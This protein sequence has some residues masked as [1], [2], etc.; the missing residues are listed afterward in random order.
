MEIVK[1]TK[2]G[3]YV[4]KHPGFGMLAYSPKTGTFY[5]IAEEFVNIDDVL[6]KVQNSMSHWLPNRESFANATNFYITQPIVINWLLSSQCNCRCPYCYAADVNDQVPTKEDIKNNVKKILKQH[7]LAVVLSGGEPMLHSELIKEAILKLGE[8]TGLIIDTNGTFIVP[9]LLPIL[10]KYN[11]VIRVSL[12]SL[13]PKNN[14]KVRPYKD[15]QIQKQAGLNTILDNINRYRSYNIPVVVQTVAT[16]INK[17]DLSDLFIELPKL[18]VQ[19]WRIFM[20]IIPNNKDRQETFMSLMIKREE[21]WVS[22]KQAI[23]K[24]IDRIKSKSRK[25]PDFPI[26]FIEGEDSIKNSVL[27]MLPDGAFATES[28]YSQEKIILTDNDIVNKINFAAHMER[29][30]NK[31]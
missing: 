15:K 10:R 17:S 13:K 27:L 23:K 8:K 20:P 31:D 3:L 4:R 22:T 11:V 18:G 19:G 12:D 24:D 9:D 14:S 1:K 26:Q 7:P 30:L 2:Q 5:A 21:S 29:Y 6:S 25:C 28:I 16:T